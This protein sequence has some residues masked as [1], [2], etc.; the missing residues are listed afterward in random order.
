MCA[1]LASGDLAA[2]GVAMDESHRSLA[3]QF[4]VTTPALDD[5]V[6]SLRGRPGVHGARM[7]GA[8]FG[9]CVVALCEPGSLDP[10]SL[11]RPAW[12]VTSV[13]GTVTARMRRTQRRR[14]S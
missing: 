11:G 4:E 7:T 3:D 12:E 14:P 1:A 5:L 2:A 8:G 6:A 10:G 9:G 13:D